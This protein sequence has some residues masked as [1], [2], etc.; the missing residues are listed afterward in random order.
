MPS[1]PL[2]ICTCSSCFGLSFIDSNGNTKQGKL[3]SSQNKSRHLLKDRDLANAPGS[4]PLPDESGEESDTPFHSREYSTEEEEDSPPLIN[5]SIKVTM[6]LLFASLQIHKLITLTLSQQIMFL[7]SLLG[8]T[9]TP[10]RAVW[11]CLW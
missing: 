7:S 5:I 2:V 6:K 9:S 11:T 8:S 10:K 3:I 1:Q 4:T